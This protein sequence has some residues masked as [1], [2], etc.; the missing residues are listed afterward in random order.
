M[1]YYD[2]DVVSTTPSVA[3]HFTAETVSAEHQ[4]TK[5]VLHRRDYLEA[6]SGQVFAAARR[7]TLCG[8]NARG[9]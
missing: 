2:P 1:S 7:T 5:L 3:R 4:G 9:S 6:S 8:S